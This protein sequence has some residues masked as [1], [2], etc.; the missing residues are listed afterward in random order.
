MAK[1]F[2]VVFALRCR[3]SASNPADENAR[4]DSIS[5]VI[6]DIEVTSPA[7]GTFAYRALSDGLLSRKLRHLRIPVLFSRIDNVF[8]QV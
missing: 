5:V 1:T 2:T 7:K 6:H 3:K 4:V 8:V